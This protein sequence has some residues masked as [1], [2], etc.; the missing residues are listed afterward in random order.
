MRRA[1]K[2]ALSTLLLV[3]AL[4]SSAQAA[5]TFDCKFEKGASSAQ[6]SPFSFVSNAGTVTC[7]PAATSNRVL[8]G[9]VAFRSIASSSV[10]MTW[11][12]V[13]MTAIG[14]LSNTAGGNFDVYLFGLINPASGAQTLSVSW[15]GGAAITIL[16]GWML[17]DADQ[18]TG[19]QNFTSNA[20]TSTSMSSG[21]VTSA[22]G[23][24]VI[25]GTAD[26][27]ASSASIS[28]GTSDWD[29]RAFTGNY[30]G[31]HIASSGASATVS[32]TLG[33]NVAWGVIAT[34]VI[35][36]SGGGGGTPKRLLLLGCCAPDLIPPW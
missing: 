11:N 3:L 25:A 34:D 2:I 16:G 14:S 32:W 20:A 36:F 12:S 19:W 33:S 15:T 6:T 27:D 30:E 28:S 5:V 31:G 1:S 35:A 22:S 8:I 26:N 4:G 10:A 13:P 23:N 18:A 7:T 17:S 24:M 29:E 21:A 9:Y